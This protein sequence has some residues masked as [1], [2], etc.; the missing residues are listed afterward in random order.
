MSRDYSSSCSDSVGEAED[1]H[2]ATREEMEELW[3]AEEE[4]V[5]K[6]EFRM[7]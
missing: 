6:A 2:V 4:A 7:L 5:M 1:F 3:A